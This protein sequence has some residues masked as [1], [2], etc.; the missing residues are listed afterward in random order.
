MTEVHMRTNWRT[1]AMVIAEAV[2]R[3]TLTRTK[4]KRAAIPPHIILLFP[5]DPRLSGECVIAENAW[6][7]GGSKAVLGATSI[8]L[9]PSLQRRPHT[10]HH[11]PE[12]QMARVFMRALQSA[13]HL[14]RDTDP[15]GYIDLT[16][17]TTGGPGTSV[18]V[19]ISVNGEVIHPERPILLEP[20]DIGLG[21][22]Y[23]VDEMEQAEYTD[24]MVGAGLTDSL[25]EPVSMH[26]E[27]QRVIAACN[28][29]PGRSGWLTVLEELCPCSAAAAH[30]QIHNLITQR[31]FSSTEMG[32]LDPGDITDIAAQ[33]SREVPDETGCSRQAN[34]SVQSLYD[35]TRRQILTA[36]AESVFT[37]SAAG[38][39]PAPEPFEVG[40]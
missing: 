32:G 34:C 2:K 4:N 17:G 11:A 26:E 40:W 12:V 6:F 23:L 39:A 27:I 38:P 25:V 22:L 8:Q 31:L 33:V 35:D 24:D 37:A 15:F 19:T 16:A 20:S 3:E 7:N 9:D 18:D 10:G 28:A 29:L 30:A 1:A 36:S 5:P 14:S 21:S 13:A